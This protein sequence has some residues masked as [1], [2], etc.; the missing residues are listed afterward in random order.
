[1]KDSSLEAE[2]VTKCSNY[3]CKLLN[4]ANGFGGD[5]ITLE[6]FSTGHKITFCK[7]C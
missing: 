2:S 7:V 6:A 3:S 1:M 5:K 4:D